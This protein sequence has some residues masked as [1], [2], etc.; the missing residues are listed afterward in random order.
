M[1]HGPLETVKVST[2]PEDVED[3]IAGAASPY[4]M[5]DRELKVIVC[6]FFPAANVF[7]APNDVPREFVLFAW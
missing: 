6:G 4:V 2:S 1:E 7:I 5:V 3:D